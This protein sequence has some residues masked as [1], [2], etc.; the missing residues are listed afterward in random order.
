MAADAVQPAE[1]EA[2]RLELLLLRAL[3][4]SL[5]AEAEFWRQMAAARIAR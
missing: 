4:E 1:R 2:L 3:V 5:R